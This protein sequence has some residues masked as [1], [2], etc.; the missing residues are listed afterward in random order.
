MHTNW[1]DGNSK[2]GNRIKNARPLKNI[3]FYCTHICV[4][5]SYG[6]SLY[7]FDCVHTI[8]YR[9]PFSS[10]PMND[11]RPFRFVIELRICAHNS[12]I[13]IFT[14]SILFL[15]VDFKI[16]GVNWW[17]SVR[18]NHLSKKFALS[19]IGLHIKKTDERITYEW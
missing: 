15:S 3:V 9:R 6:H 4:S 19:F 17:Y 13:S 2:G 16:E 1:R 7:E 12:Y 10:M 8:V 18:L 11:F 5:V 14:V